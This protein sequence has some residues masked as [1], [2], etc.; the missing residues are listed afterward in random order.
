M[1]TNSRNSFVDI[2]RGIAMLLVV[3]G[4]TITGCTVG[5]QDSFLFNVIWSLQMPLFILISGYVTKYSRGC[6]DIKSF[7]QFVW[8]RT[9]AYL[10]PL[11]VWTFVVHGLVCGQK[12]FF[13]ITWL[14]YHMDSGYWFLFTI[15]TISLCF[16]LSEFL[17]KKIFHTKTR[18]FIAT[19]LLFGLFGIV[20]L[21]IGKVAGMNFLGIKLTVYYI[22]FY[23]LGYLWGKYGENLF[24]IKRAETIKIG[25]AISTLVWVYIL[26]K[27]NLYNM[28]DDGYSVIIRFVGSITGCIAVCGLCNGIFGIIDNN[29]IKSGSAKIGKFFHWA[30]FH[31]LE[32]YLVHGLVLDILRLAESPQLMS[33]SGIMLTI[34]NFILTMA[35]LVVVI[36]LTNQNKYLRL[37]LYGKTK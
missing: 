18:E 6:K 4:H 35:L 36:L 9:L 5:S 21:A 34:A 13:D 11:V 2:V 3:L 24:E 33:V 26:F 37:F 8:R 23:W 14:V 1:N 10:L 30:G 7:G 32:I 12:Q 20:L 27:F 25:I 16:G 19:S 17:A 15:W 31:S 22:P 29:D 28:P